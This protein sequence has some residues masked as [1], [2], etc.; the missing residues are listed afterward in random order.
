[1]GYPELDQD[2]SIILETRNVKYKS[3]SLDA[4]L[5]NKRIILIDNKKEVIPPQDISLSSIRIVEMGE[6]AIRDPF[7]LLILRT[8]SGE[9]RQMVITFPRQ[10][11]GDRRR[12]C[13]EWVKKLDTLRPAP[14]ADSVPE[15]L[16]VLAE[17]PE[18][19]PEVSLPARTVIPETRPVK[20]KIEIARPLSKII[21]KAPISPIPVETST[22]P[23]GTFCTR[24][25]NRVPLNSTFCNHCGTPIVHVPEKAAAPQPAVHQVQVPPT[26][27]VSPAAERQNRPIEQIIHSIEPLI[28]DSVPRTHSGP[29]VRKNVPEQKAESPEPVPPAPEP[30]KESA[31]E[32]I[33]PVLSKTESPIAPAKEP[34]PA[35]A[36]AAPQ[37]AAPE[38]LTPAPPPVPEGNKPDYRTIGIIAAVII[39][40][41]I[42]IILLSGFTTGPT[43]V[44]QENTTAMKVTSVATTVPS[45]KPTTPIIQVTTLGTPATPTVMVPQSGVWVRVTYSGTYTGTIGIPGDVHQSTDSGDRFYQL[46]TVN[47]TVLVSVQK[48]DGSLEKLAVAIYKNG[49][50][51]KEDSTI[52]PKGIV[53]VQF[54]LK[55]VSSA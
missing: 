43:G 34:E 16:P 41:I 8:V 5:T 36:P 37:P 50:L 2:E 11:G 53:D 35:P 20:K 24:C 13:N 22:L 30:P 38:P 42:G 19:K 48:T 18:K 39:A 55:T 46:S 14:V 17:E 6:N 49:V 26:Q 28:E 33:W 51:V 44:P 27:P 31:P 45:P 7:L 1:M 40:I 54:D 47:G 15:D 52:A 32:V 4:I 21:E 25:G 10:A 23:S 29:L 9:K 12:E 3:I